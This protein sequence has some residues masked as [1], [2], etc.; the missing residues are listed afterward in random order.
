M[1]TEKNKVR[2]NY[3]R[4]QASRLGLC[5]KKSKAK[6]WSIDNQCGYM[7][8][9]ADTSFILWGDRYQLEIDEVAEL[10]N[11]YEEKIKK[12]E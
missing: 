6:K 7:I 10:L 1:E 3:L 9:D 11:E 5:L 4:R 2:E 12:G 8:L